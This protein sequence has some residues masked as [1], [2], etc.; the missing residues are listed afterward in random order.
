MRQ[1]LVPPER[2]DSPD[3]PYLQYERFLQSGG[4]ALPD[5]P[6]GIPRSPAAWEDGFTDYPLMNALIARDTGRY[7][8]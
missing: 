3:H 7:P 4:F 2:Y 6:P 1:N 8:P 5:D